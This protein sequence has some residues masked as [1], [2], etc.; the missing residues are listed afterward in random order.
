VPE[1]LEKEKKRGVGANR[2]ELKVFLFYCKGVGIVEV[3][4]INE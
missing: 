3:S 2:F 1:N 4:I